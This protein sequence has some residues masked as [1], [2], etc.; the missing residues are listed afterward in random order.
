MEIG[1]LDTGQKVDLDLDFETLLLE[2]VTSLVENFS[3]QGTPTPWLPGWVRMTYVPDASRN[4]AEAKAER[5]FCQFTSLVTSN[6][7]FP[8]PAN[9]D[10][11]MSSD[12][13]NE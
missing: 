2:L 4:N 3:G 11:L 13:Q 10:Q 12:V 7:F 1:F 5:S 6:H 8:V 9:R